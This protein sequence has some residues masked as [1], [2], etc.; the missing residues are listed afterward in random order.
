LNQNSVV[1]GWARARGA[2]PQVVQA[3][4][5]E[6]IGIIQ[7]PCPEKTFAG[8]QRPPM[9]V[10]EYDTDSYRQHCIALLNGLI[11]DLLNYREHEVELVGVIGIEDSPSCCPQKGIF[12]QILLHLLAEH[13]FSTRTVQVPPDFRED[14]PREDFLA[15]V[16]TWLKP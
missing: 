14:A 6:G 4:L 7:L 10:E 3:I 11:D 1:K 5:A 12:Y 16:R 9:T 2:F 13:G 8:L 15:E